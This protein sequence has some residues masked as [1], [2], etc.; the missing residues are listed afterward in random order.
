LGGGVVNPPTWTN[1]G[2]K[3]TIGPLG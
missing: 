3:V 1:G 2:T